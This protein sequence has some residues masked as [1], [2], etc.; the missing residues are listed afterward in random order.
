M[1]SIHA[2]VYMIIIDY[3]KQN[4]IKS[5]IKDLFDERYY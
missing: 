1:P 5:T 2:F 3:S 4:A